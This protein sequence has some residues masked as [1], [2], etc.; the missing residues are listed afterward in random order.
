[1]SKNKELKRGYILIGL[2]FVD[3]YQRDEK[4]AWIKSRSF[5][6]LQY[7]EITVAPRKD[8]RWAIVDGQQRYHLAM[9][10]G[11]TRMWAKQLPQ[12]DLREE[13]ALFFAMQTGRTTP[14]AL[15]RFR[16]GIY[17]REEETLEINKQVESAGFWVDLRK[18][19]K[20]PVRKVE[21]VGHLYRIYRE[22]HSPLIIKR[23]LQAIDAAW[24]CEPLAMYGQ[25]IFGVARALSK[26]EDDDKFIEKMKRFTVQRIRGYAAEIGAMGSNTSNLGTL[27]F[28]AIMRA[29]N[30]RRRRNST[31]AIVSIVSQEQEV[32]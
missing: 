23:A 5:D 8:G 27:Y 15:D 25:M 19:T 13:A 4:K 32:M 21:S 16:A 30:S 28:L 3:S 31:K 17:A 1:M 29:Y 11:L 7:T 12:M 10:S 2:L 26:I 22:V 20:D 6:P 9:A 14:T 24:D 18:G